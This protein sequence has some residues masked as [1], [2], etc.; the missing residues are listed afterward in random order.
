MWEKK[1]SFE[2]GAGSGG[3]Q[4]EGRPNAGG[5]EG[6]SRLGAKVTDKDCV[7]QYVIQMWVL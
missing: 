4:G 5:K 7:Y 6:D 3:G 2:V 1:H